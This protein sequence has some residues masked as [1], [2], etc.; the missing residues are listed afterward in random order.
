MKG[1]LTHKEQS[2][3]LSIINTKEPAKWSRVRLVTLWLKFTG[4]HPPEGRDT[5]LKN[6]RDDDV[7]MN[8]FF[9]AAKIRMPEL[10]KSTDKYLGR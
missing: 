8:L 7:K 4:Y 2:E 5:F 9:K 10:F 1:F 3:A 6:L